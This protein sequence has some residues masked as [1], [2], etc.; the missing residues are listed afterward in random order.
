M[1]VRCKG[2]KHWRQK[3]PAPIFEALETSTFLAQLTERELLDAY[4]VYGNQVHLATLY[5]RYA[6]L[7]YGVC[8]KYL[9]Q[10][11]LAQDACASVYEKM[12]T[13]LRQHKVDN[14]GGWL[15]TVAR[16]HCLQQLR[17]KKRRHETVVDE[18]FVQIED[19]WHLDEA[20]QKEALFNQLSECIE[21][22]SADQKLMIELFY[23]KE[24]SYLQIESETGTP[25]NAVRSHIQNGRRNLKKCMETTSSG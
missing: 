2:P 9:E 15:Q 6:G 25:W 18:N 21:T 22:L 13:A 17:E 10:P 3:I 5:Q 14:F 11:D 20:M 16:N 24:K 19:D 23:L 4:Y 12:V 1:P 8:Y 7:L